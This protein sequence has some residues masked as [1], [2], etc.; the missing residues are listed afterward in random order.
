MNRRRL[1][2]DVEMSREGTLERL[3][4][5]GQWTRVERRVTAWVIQG[6]WWSAE[7]RREYMR[8]LTTTG[9]VEVY[10]EGDTWWLSHVLD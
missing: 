7:V 4:W 8:V 2:V 1:P 10:R 3:R 5:K 9:V 6:Q